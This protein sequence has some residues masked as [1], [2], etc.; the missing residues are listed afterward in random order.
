MYLGLILSFIM[1]CT[2][3]KVECKKDERVVYKAI[4]EASNEIENKYN[5]H[6][7]GISEQADHN[8]D[9]KFEVIGL[10]F[11]S[12]HYISKTEARKIVINIS[13]IFLTKLNTEQVRP[14]LT[15]FPFTEK[16][17]KIS[18]TSSMSQAKWDLSQVLT[19]GFSRSE[20]YYRYKIQNEKYKTHDV[21]EPFSEALKIV[22]DEISSPDENEA[23]P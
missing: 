5:L 8:N 2:T 10:I 22:Q 21:F 9:C 1:G 16:N 13:E 7:G 23:S 15:V 4:R 18:V 6:F 17:L 20:V 14:F 12:D 19:F 11:Q 3:P